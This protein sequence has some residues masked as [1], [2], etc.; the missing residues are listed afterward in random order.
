MAERENVKRSRDAV[1]NAMAAVSILVVDD[2][3][4][5]RSML[6]D[7]LTES[8]YQVCTASSG[9][10][11][12]RLVNNSDFSIVITDMRMPGID[13]VEVTKK[14]RSAKADV[15]V[16]VITGY[17]SIQSAME[18]LKEGAYDYISKPFNIEEIKVVV[19]RAVE[20]QLL[21]KEAKEKEQYQRLSILDGLTE[22]YNR[23]HFDAM[24]PDELMRAAKYMKPLSCMMIDVD[25]F[26][27]FNDSQGHQAGD[28]ALKKVAQILSGSVRFTDHVF[29]YG[30][31]EF[32]TLL[33]ET[34]KAKAIIV[35]KRLRMLVANS[36]FID[37]KALTTAHLTIS[38]GL[39]SYPDDSKDPRSLV[40]KADECLYYAKETGRNRICFVSSDGVQSEVK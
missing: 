20:R 38:I 21:L 34:D 27:N 5:M 8:G 11:A 7:V 28:W 36:K 17:A 35:A 33:P 32:V 1:A 29:R 13:G 23:R 40:A 30:G 10:E 18:V 31:E 37:K 22:I 6:K 24:L 12:V 16:I 15:C 14:F 39:S 3:D 2:E 9:E 19:R 25:H 26:K 4:I